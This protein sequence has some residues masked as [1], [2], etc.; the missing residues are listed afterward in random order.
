MKID[1]T[2]YGRLRTGDVVGTYYGV[3][4][5]DI[6]L[7]TLSTYDGQEDE[8][9]TTSVAELEQ[10]EQ[11]EEP[12]VEIV[13]AKPLPECIPDRDKKQCY[14]ICLLFVVFVVMLLVYFF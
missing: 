12:Y 13:E 9:S 7:E 2:T 8:T 4:E 6:L 10:Y 1:H 3:D 5:H 11:L 14:C